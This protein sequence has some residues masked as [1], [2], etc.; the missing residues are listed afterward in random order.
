MSDKVENF[1][2]GEWL[3]DGGSAATGIRE[4]LLVP[5]VASGVTWGLG[6]MAGESEGL[7][8]RVLVPSTS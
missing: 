2:L 6:E 1:N 8:G 5:D 4:V 3:L 7:I